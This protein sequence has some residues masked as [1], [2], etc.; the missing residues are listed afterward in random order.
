MPQQQLQRLQLARLAP[1]C[2]YG[3]LHMHCALSCLLSKF[4]AEVGLA[5]RTVCTRAKSRQGNACYLDM[6]NALEAMQQ[7]VHSSCMYN[8]ES[9]TAHTL[10]KV[11]L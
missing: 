10:T 1:R 11:H 5:V 6:D 9:A 7:L 8:G 2:P 3:N 4:L